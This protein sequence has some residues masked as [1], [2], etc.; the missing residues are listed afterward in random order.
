[1]L[2][3]KSKNFKSEYCC[4]VVQI[5]EVNPIEG[6]DFLGTTL[7]EGRTIVVRKD[8]CKTGDILFY[9][10]NETQLNHDFLYINNLFDDCTI[11]VD[12]EKKG[13]FNKS[14]RV[15]M[16]KLRGQ[17]SMG[18][19]FGF[20][21]LKNWCPK[22]TEND[23]LPVGSDFDTVNGEL[24]IKAYIPPIKEYPVRLSKD[25]KRNKKLAKFDRI[26]PGEFS[27]HY[28]TSQLNREMYRIKPDDMVTISVKLHGTSFIMGNVKTKKPRWNGLYSK[29]FNH[30]PK[31]L[32]F[33][34]E[35][36]DNIYSSRTVIKNQY[37]NSNVSSGYYEKDVW[38]EYFNLLKGLIPHGMTIYGEI[39]GYI[40][41]SNS[42]IQKGYDYGCKPGKNK[43]M[44]YRIN[45][46]NYD[47]I[48]YE[49]DVREVRDWTMQLISLHPELADRIHPIDILFHGR[50]MDYYPQCDLSN[51]WHD[52]VLEAMKK[53]K[54]FGMEMNEPLCRNK[55]PREG[56]VLRI[57]HDPIKEAFKLKTLKFLGKE[58]ELI[59]M[60]EVD[61]EMTQT[62]YE[63]TTS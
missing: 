57:D 24:F 37:I 12:P 8:Q 60:G 31:F 49:W 41:G 63:Y 32:Q 21:E 18:Y 13:Y 30:L 5:G 36:Y 54:R 39:I 2:L 42:M 38:G 27:F 20:D 55:I 11:N 45:T 16:I 35:D 3:T 53:D 51:H 23:I 43:L 9:A 61:I 28:D 46:K 59:D 40:G 1:M 6:S 56:I 44:I 50:L 47:G 19:L 26:I 22:L 10:A 25:Q 14:G 29:L 58:A 48:S 52:D 33:T 34:V 7:V 4:T 17:I 15:R 62:D